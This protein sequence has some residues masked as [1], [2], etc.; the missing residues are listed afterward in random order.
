MPAS[1]Y[2][3]WKYHDNFDAGIQANAM[4][5]GDN[6]HRGAVVGS[7]LGAAN[8]VSDKWIEGLLSQS[9]QRV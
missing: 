1:L 5:G 4:V 9:I 3:A 6:C 8:G 7:L 2:L